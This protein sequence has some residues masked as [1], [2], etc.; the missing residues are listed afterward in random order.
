MTTPK[1]TPGPWVFRRGPDDS[2]FTFRLGDTRERTLVEQ[3]FD[4]AEALYPD[5]GDQY[6]TAE[7]NAYLIA[8]A[9]DLLAVSEIV[10]ERG[11]HW[12]DCPMRFG[13]TVCCCPLEPARA[14]IAKVRGE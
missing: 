1:H 5:D 10:A 6:E 14:A 3:A 2:G 11:E 9:P 7:A 4:Y 12:I 8:A 13:T